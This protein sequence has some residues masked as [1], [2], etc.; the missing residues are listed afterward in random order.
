MPAARAL[1]CPFG[2]AK[3]NNIVHG[4]MLVKCDT[5]KH[6]RMDGNTDGTSDICDYVSSILDEMINLMSKAGHSPLY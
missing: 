4:R 1:S 2:A 5:Q 6:K 3:V